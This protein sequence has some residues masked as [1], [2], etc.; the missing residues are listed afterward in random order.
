MKRKKQELK[1]K[2]RQGKKREKGQLVG[3]VGNQ[4]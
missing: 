1:S 4:K 2:Q 3:L